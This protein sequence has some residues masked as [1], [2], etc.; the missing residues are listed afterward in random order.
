[1]K[2]FL[3]LIFIVSL[4]PAQQKFFF[5]LNPGASLY[6]TE[7]SS[8]VI[9]EKSIEWFGGGSIGYETS[10]LFETNLRFTYDVAFTQVNDALKFFF[11]S[12]KGPD[13]IDTFGADYLLY[14]HNV[15][16]TQQ[17]KLDD[18]FSF[19]FGPTLSWVNRSI[20][21]HDIPRF[22][23]IGPATMGFEDRLATL[24]AGAAAS[25][26]ME[27]P[28]DD[29]PEH[30]FFFAGIKSRILF[31]LWTD[32]RGRNV[33]NYRQEFILAQINVGIGYSY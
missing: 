19:S 5:S 17:F 27:V 7:N 25:V 14:L 6:T 21:I 31:S 29:T 28:F 12:D 18:Q 2:K 26:T 32:A 20:I 4:L 13:V 3:S 10:D 24:C 16:V 8:K 1:M 15:D 30:L 23:E 11:T 9:G 22:S 33:S